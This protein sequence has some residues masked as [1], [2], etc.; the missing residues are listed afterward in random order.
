MKAILAGS[1]N[2]FIRWNDDGHDLGRCHR[3]QRAN[4]H[5]ARTLRSDQRWSPHLR[6]RSR[7]DRDAD[8]TFGKADRPLCGRRPIVHQ[9]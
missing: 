8:A 7:W 9:K 5:S 1:D 2:A 4:R 3:I 6:H